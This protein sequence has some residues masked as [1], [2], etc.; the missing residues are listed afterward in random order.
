M[1]IGATR[2]NLEQQR[3][4]LQRRRDE[5]KAALGIRT[6]RHHKNIMAHFRK[7]G[8]K[9]RS[10]L[11]LEYVNT[12]EGLERINRELERLNLVGPED[13]GPL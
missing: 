3:A 10:E 4:N 13:D 8:R 12:G 1:T 2:E 6:R 9:I 7:N 5:L 11:F